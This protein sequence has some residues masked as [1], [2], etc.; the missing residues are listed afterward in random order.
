[1]DYLN[2]LIIYNFADDDVCRNGRK[3]AVDNFNSIW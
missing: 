3:G 2:N 1:M